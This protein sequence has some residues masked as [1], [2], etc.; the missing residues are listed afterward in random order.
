VLSAY[1]ARL[2]RDRVVGNI[3]DVN[4][5][6]WRLPSDAQSSRLAMLQSR[7]GARAVVTDEPQARLNAGWL[8]TAGTGDSYTLLAGAGDSSPR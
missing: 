5:A 6:F 4:G 1:W 3:E 2:D 8:R 7:S